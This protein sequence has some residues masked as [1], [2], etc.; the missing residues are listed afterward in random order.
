MSM[1]SLAIKNRVSTYLIVFLVCIF[2]IA[3]YMS[4]EKAEDP[5]YTIKTAVITTN[6][7]GATATEMA[8]LVS[9]KIENEVRNMDSLNY[10]DSK[11][12]PGQSN[13]FVNLKQKYWDP[14]DQWIELRNKIT[15][16]VTPQ[17]PPG[18]QAPII[19]TYFGDVYGTVLSL[20]SKDLS[21]DNLYKQADKLKDELLFS[22]PEI[23]KIEIFGTQQDVIYININND[24]M[25]EIGIT[26][27][28]ISSTLQ[29]A[30][31]VVRGG[32]LENK[33][34]RIVVNP[35]GTFN[36]I[37][38][39]KK[40]VLSGGKF[41]QRIYLGE[42]ASV[43]KGYINPASL[44]TFNK[45]TKSIVL[46]LALTSGENILELKTKTEKVIKSFKESLPLGTDVSFVYNQGNFVNNK[47]GSF[48]SSL[49]QALVSIVAIMLLFLGLKT[50]LIVASL[51][52]VSIA[53]T[54]IGLK[55]FGYGINQM[56]LAG[57]IIALGMLVDNAVVMSEN[58]MV[59]CQ[60]GM[61]KKDACIESAKDLAIPLFTGSLTTCVAMLPIIG[62][63]ASMGQYVGPMAIVVFLALGASWVINQ[64]FIPL[65][66][67]DYLDPKA[68]KVVNY[69]T[70]KL[71]FY[72]RKMLIWLLKNIKTSM[73][74]TIGSLV[75]GIGLFKFI[76]SEFMPV[77]DTPVMSS[78]IRLPKGASIEAT[79]IIVA[80]ISDYIK[81]KYYV[82]NINPL[83]PTIMDY[84]LTGGT[85][86]IY[87]KDG[88]LDWNSYVGAGGPRYTLGYAP[89]APQSEF[90]Y[91]LFS[92]TNYKLIPAYSQ[93]IDK[94]IQD[95]YP[96]VTIM[97]KPLQTGSSSE[98]DLS[99]Q[100]ISQDTKV[101]NESVDELENYLKSLDA[102]GIVKNNWGNYVPQISVDI[103]YNKASL[104][105]LTSQE[106]ANAIQFSL[107]GFNATLFY[108]FQ[109]PPINTIIPIKV[110]GTVDYKDQL[111]AL[112]S[113]QISNSKGESVSLQ[114]VANLNIE[115]IP[116]FVYKRN[117][118]STIEVQ[119]SVIEGNS[120]TDTN[121]II[122]KWIENKMQ[123]DWKDKGISFEISG[124]MQTSQ[125]NSAGLAAGVPIALLI[126]AVI[127][128]MQFNSIKKG[129]II[130]TT[131]PLA[132]L[133]C[134]LGLLITRLSFGF[135]AIVG[136]ISLA[137][138]VLNH[139][140][141]LI[142]K[143]TIEE[144]IIKRDPCNAIV[145]GCQ[146]RLRPILLTVLTTLAGLLPLYFFGGPLFAQLA[147]VMIF[148][149]ALDA[150]LCLGLIPVI[151]TVVFKVDFKD[152]EY[153]N[154]NL[155]VVKSQEEIEKIDN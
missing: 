152:Y 109:A 113:I 79:N 3:A 29:Q 110:K 155:P 51:T 88:I 12:L 67:L 102:I 147:A 32:T 104:A 53:A 98:L 64:T 68:T 5:G 41:N 150:S 73:A 105:G 112:K 89:E 83:P 87:E 146:T 44:L 18:V 7:P 69:N 139:T 100:L 97:T 35:S 62:N 11:N 36:N 84:F 121:V 63:R 93:D 82:G 131:I 75:L 133:G 124:T 56:T 95:K 103:D 96:N 6:W 122:E 61:K 30:N 149:L 151:Y 145:I 74:I 153:I 94:Y 129:L 57:L 125:E 8:N 92:V 65:I 34:N 76:P 127:V 37:E 120:I 66:S 15:T 47:I 42:I 1:T 38:S 59:L 90:A 19:N 116:T 77:S 154:D 10:V 118:I 27:E 135:M 52:P 114:Q 40:I 20:S 134:S 23:G 126:M 86:K 85:S 54:L 2:G 132:L 136:V 106:V 99:Y 119:A 70:D 39:I 46:A 50:G 16:F 49:A 71:Y 138:V 143:I 33:G 17:L 14:K 80:D 72:Y 24:K 115:Y 117:S 101:L 4:S 142:D 26:L 107:Q 45:D 28:Q 22:V 13:V 144:D 130:M 58:I 137:G 128:M 21:Y 111:T 140:I 43:E 148:G 60:Q 81:K 108:D 9:K 78:Y 123:T 48:L 55:V 141:V 25:A 31:M 91:M